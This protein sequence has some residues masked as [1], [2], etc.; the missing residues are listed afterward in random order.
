MTLLTVR[1]EDLQ[2]VANVA[3]EVRHRIHAYPEIGLNLPNTQKIIID[4]LQKAAVDEI[5]HVG[6]EGVSGI[7]AV[8]NGTHPGRTIGLRGDSDALPLDEN[9]G[10]AYSSQR[11]G[12]MH[13]CGHD[14]HVACV[15]AAIAYLAQ[16]RNFAGKLVAIFQPGEEGFAGA[17]FMV[18]DALVERFGIDEFYALHS[19]PSVDV[20]SVAFVPGYATA[21]A[22]GFKVTFKG[23]GGHGSRP[24]MTHDPV[25]AMG[26]AIVA[27]QSIAARNADPNEACVVS[28]GCAQAGSPKGLS[29]IPETAMICGT[30]R[31]FSPEMRDLI[32]NRIGVICQGIAQAHEMQIDYE[33]MR[34]YPAMYNNPE[35]VADAKRF[36]AM[37]IGKDQ[38][39]DFMRTPGGEDFSFMLNERP[40]CLFRL[41]MKDE[42]HT[43]SV[44]NECFDFNDKAI[45][46]GAAVLLTIA[47]HRMASQN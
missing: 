33:Y 34:L 27:L 9:T 1:P 23:K 35:R 44:H 36:A 37:A 12:H 43:A 22:D 7:V 39:K 11:A 25:V 28:V 8:V 32:E 38:V 40:G 30:T 19:E 16:H 47:L 41:G 42:T 15:L 18:E 14:G 2:E 17:R 6:G 26:E 21:N 46:T 20:G 4:A 10:V 3:V 31:S 13:A 45:A 5:A 29:V 24:Q